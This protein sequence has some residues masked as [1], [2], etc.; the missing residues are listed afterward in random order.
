MSL[1]D[2]T[3]GCVIDEKVLEE[4]RANEFNIGRV[5]RFRYRTRYFTDSGIIGTKGFVAEN[6]QRFKH[7]FQSKHPQKPK[8]VTGIDGLYSLKRLSC[9]EHRLGQLQ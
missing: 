1:A 5:Q 9:L 8:P 2:K 6:Y 7:L 3:A 4:E